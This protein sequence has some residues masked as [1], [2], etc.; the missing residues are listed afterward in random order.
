MAKRLVAIIGMVSGIAA[1]ACSDATGTL[2]AGQTP[3]VTGTWYAVIA[4]PGGIDVDVTFAQSG[5]SVTGAVGG[6][7]GY[8]GFSGSVS[9]QVQADSSIRLRFTLVPTF[10][11]SY[12]RTVDS[13]IYT[14]R[15][16]RQGTYHRLYGTVVGS[17]FTG[18]SATFVKTCPSGNI[19]VLC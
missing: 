16:G 7:N 3:S 5:T 12:G 17:G 11:N 1:A 19:M 8:S 10:S 9:G 6:N 14:G 2:N 4:S 18:D 13:L 15:V